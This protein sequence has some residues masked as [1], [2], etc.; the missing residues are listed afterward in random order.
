VLS[1]QRESVLRRAAAV[2]ASDAATAEVVEA[3]RA[4]GIRAILLKGPVLTRWL[5]RH[6]LD[7]VYGDIDLLVSRMDFDAAAGVLR[8]L[9]YQDDI[10]DRRFGI[11]SGTGDSYAKHFHRD[12]SR[13][14]AVDLHRGLIW[15]GTDSHA[16]WRLLRDHTDTMSVGGSEV[17]VLTPAALALVVAL[18]AA[19]HGPA[20][21]P[22]EDLSRALRR[23]DHDI[24]RQA[25][26]LA[27]LLGVE[28]AFA[29]GL[30]GSAPGRELAE[31]LE[32]TRAASVEVK[33]LSSGNTT[34]ALPLEQLRQ[35]PSL[36]RRLSFLLGKLV[37]S[38]DYMRLGYPIA[39]RGVVALVYAY[40]YRAAKLAREFPGARRALKAAR[41]DNA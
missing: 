2:M 31:R 17:S 4:H 19:Q 26:A 3:L 41:D 1:K 34:L 7:R 20:P 23:F 15:S 10:P 13:P 27:S 14:A 25:A 12:S 33:L 8:S 39:R 30:R 18:H 32:L 16:A 40:F 35:E 29:A 9:G 22:R 38:A 28:E 24:W 21:V 11:D 37:P 5:Y 36:T 6:R